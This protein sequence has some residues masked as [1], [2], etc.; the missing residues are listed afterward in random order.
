MKKKRRRTKRPVV[1][2]H[3]TETARAIIARTRAAQAEIDAFAKDANMKSLEKYPIAQ[4]TGKTQRAEVNW[5]QY[6]GI[7]DAA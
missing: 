3:L 4:V 7:Y 6:Q 1:Y 2:T 5:Y